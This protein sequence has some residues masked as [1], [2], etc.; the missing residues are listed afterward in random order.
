MIIFSTMIGVDTFSWGKLILLKKEKWNDLI[1]EIILKS[2]F[3]ITHEVKKEFEHF[4]PDEIDLLNFVTVLAK[5]EIDYNASFIKGFDEADASLLEYSKSGDFMLI[6]EDHL[7]IN[8]NISGGNQI[9]QL[10]DF[11]GIL[12]EQEFISG[13]ELYHLTKRLRKMTN[14]TKKKEKEILNLRKA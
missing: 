12:F 8:E 3:F 10:V 6:T 11:F 14:I 13:K 2:D 9:I 4:F 1:S 7:M 5:M